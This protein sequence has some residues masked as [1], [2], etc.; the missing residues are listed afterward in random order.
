MRVLLVEDDPELSDGIASFLRGQGDTVMQESDGMRADQLL[1]AESVDFALVDV[2]L[3][4]LGGYELV[5]RIRSRQQAVPVMLITARDA[6]D[7]RIYGLD[8]GADDYLA[9]P[10]QLAEL[11]ARMRAVLRRGKYATTQSIAFGPLTL[12]LDG[13]LAALNG[14]PLNLT[15][16]EWTL[17]EALAAADGRTVPKDHLQADASGNAVEVYISRLRPRLEPAGLLIRTVRG[18]GYRLELGPG[19]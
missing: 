16:R 14:E 17:L 12:D 1:Q 11:T 9:K 2:G 7:D 5:R 4:G 18:F 6:L 8:L 3:P 19:H 13:R 15:A 10:F